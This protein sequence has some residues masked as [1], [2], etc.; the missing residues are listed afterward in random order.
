ME[1]NVLLTISIP[2]YNR[3]FYLNQLLDSLCAQLVGVQPKVELLIVDNDSPDNTSAVV[4]SY[5]DSCTIRYIKNE[6]NIGPDHNFIKCLSEANGKYVLLFGD[7]DL[8]LEGSIQYLIDVLSSGDYGV[9]H[10]KVLSF[11]DEDQVVDRSIRYEDG[12]HIVGPKDFMSL[13]H[14]NTTFISAN[15]INKQYF[16]ASIPSVFLK[17]NLAQLAWTFNAALSAKDNFFVGDKLIAGR[18]FNSS[19]YD[20]CRVFVKNLN[21]IIDYYVDRGF[22]RN[23]FSGTIK[24]LLMVYYPAN[25]VKSRCGHHKVALDSCNHLLWKYYKNNIYYW[26]FIVPAMLLPKKIAWLIF[27]LIDR[28]RSK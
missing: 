8:F 5:E 20:L 21:D 14:I 16:E 22:S 25:I 1:N 12:K 26:V 24:R 19:G 2:T 4:N 11:S 7:D 3:S 23:V 13:A 10:L 27:S 9:V 28:V 17:S 18:L 6:R 15:I